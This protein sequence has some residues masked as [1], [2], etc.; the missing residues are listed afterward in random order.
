MK[1]FANKQDSKAISGSEVVIYKTL[2][3]GVNNIV[4]ETE[5]RTSTKSGG[6]L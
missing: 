1:D 6:V 4:Y 3:D 5:K 2:E